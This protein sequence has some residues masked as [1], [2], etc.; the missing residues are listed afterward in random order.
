MIR[1]YLTHFT[2]QNYIII[3]IFPNLF[4]LRLLRR[5]IFCAGG[6]PIR[7]MFLQFEKITGKKFDYTD[8][9]TIFAPQKV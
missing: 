6:V 9:I 8:K 5:H 1:F 7:R 3:A 2:H 4:R